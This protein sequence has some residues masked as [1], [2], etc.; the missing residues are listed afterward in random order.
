M[1][2]IPRRA[3]HRTAKLAS[4]PLGV[5]GRLAAG[6]GKRLVGQDAAQI[7]AEVSAKTA[8]QLFSVLGQLKGG[9]MKFGQALSVFEAAVPDE[10][11]GPYREALTKLQ[12]AAPPM[13]AS[14]VHRVLDE[15]LGRAWRKRFSEFDDTPAASAS[16]GQVHRAIWHD[17]REVAV[18]VQYP[19][20]D[21]A[22]RSDLRQ[23]TRFSRLFQSLAPGAEVKP[24]L[25]ELQE[26]MVEELDY[27][28]EADNQ[29]AFAKVFRDDEAVRVPAVVASAPKVVVTEWVTGTP[30]SRIISDGDREQRNT[31]GQLLAEFHYSAPS[32]VGLL[33][34]DPH[35]GNFMLLADGRLAVIDFGAVSRLPDGLPTTL[36]RM[37]RLALEDK[38]A[39]LLDLLRAERFVQPDRELRG[40]DVLAYLAPFVDPVRTPTFHFTR[41]WLQ[42]QAER[43]GDLRSPDFRTG[44]SLNLPPDYLLIHRVTLGATG[45]LCQLDA[46][47]DA[48]DVITK[49]QPGFT[50]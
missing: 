5:A 37:I 1:A 15:Q 24:L 33:H 42:R 31:A 40:E 39:E 14:S 41:R 20:A 4:L 7:N 44:R 9:A 43:V 49:W 16:I 3:A 23:L 32:R 17:G 22:L 50:D 27:R 12:A 21:E 46:E 35:P 18:K 11:A 38:P 47:V 48:L 25:A 29:R 30:Y 8:E 36:G 26:R 2:D 34:A 28:T 10:M 45:I 6:W 19:G 13:A